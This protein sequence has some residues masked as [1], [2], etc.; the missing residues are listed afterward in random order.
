MTPITTEQGV[1]LFDAALACQQPCLVPAPVGAAALA[2]LAR[3]TRCP[4]FCRG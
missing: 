3:T 4:R 1:A 2:R